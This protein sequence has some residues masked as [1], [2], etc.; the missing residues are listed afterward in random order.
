MSQLGTKISAAMLLVNKNWTE[1]SLNQLNDAFDKIHQTLDDVK[2][3][4][5]NVSAAINI[6]NSIIEKH[7][8][9]LYRCFSRKP[10]DIESVA[11]CLQL[12]TSM[13]DVNT[14]TA[15]EVSS[16][17]NF[18]YKPFTNLAR[19]HYE[20]KDSPR[21]HYIK[22][23][24][25]I[26]RCG[27]LEVITQSLKLKDFFQV[28]IKNLTDDPPEL[29]LNVLTTFL[30]RV[31][32]NAE[33]PK[34]IKVLFFNSYNLSQFA[35]LYSNT[36]SIPKSNPTLQSNSNFNKLIRKY[37]SDDS[38]R[39]E[40]TIS[41]RVLIHTFL[42]YIC[43]SVKHG[44]CFASKSITENKKRSMTTT[45]NPILLKF[46]QNINK[47][48]DDT[49]VQNLICRIAAN[50][51][52]VAFSYV[53]N[54]PIAIEPTASNWVPNM[55]LL[56]RLLTL[57]P[58]PPAE[59]LPTNC[60]T[61]NIAD[62]ILPYIIP[63]IVSRST[64]SRILQNPSHLT[65]LTGLNILLILLQRTIDFVNMQRQ[66]I[67]NSNDGILN[68]T[69]A[70]LFA[71][72]PDIKT[73]IKMKSLLSDSG[74]V[75]DVV[76]LR[77]V[78]VMRKYQELSPT[79][80]QME[81]GRFDVSNM[82]LQTRESTN[83]SLEL[84]LIQLLSNVPIDSFKWLQTKSSSSSP[85]RILLSIYQNTARN[86]TR[87]LTLSLIRKILANTGLFEK[88]EPE[89]DLWIECLRDH[90][91]HDIAFINDWLDETIRQLL[92]NPY[93]AIGV[94]TSEN[95]KAATSLN[96]GE[97]PSLPCSP[98]ASA[99]LLC[100]S[101]YM[102]SD[103]TEN[104]PI[105]RNLA[106]Y[107]GR[108]FKGISRY[109]CDVLGIVHKLV[110][111]VIDKEILSSSKSLI[112]NMWKLQHT[113][114]VLYHGN[115]DKFLSGFW[116]SDKIEQA[117]NP[118]IKDSLKLAMNRIKIKE[119]ESRSIKK[120]LYELLAPLNSNSIYSSLGD[121][122]NFCKDFL[123]NDYEVVINIVRHRSLII[124]GKP[125]GEECLKALLN[126]YTISDLLEELFSLLIDSV[127][128][129]NSEN[130][131]YIIPL[132]KRKAGN[133]DLE[134]TSVSPRKLK[135]LITSDSEP[136]YQ[137][138]DIKLEPYI[139]TIV[140][141]SIKTS[142]ISSDNVDV[143]L[144]EF[145]YYVAMVMSSF[146][147]EKAVSDEVELIV[148]P[149]F[150]EF[151][152]KICNWIDKVIA[153][154][155]NAESIILNI[156]SVILHNCLIDL[157]FELNYSRK[158]LLK[159]WLLGYARVV[160]T[161][162]TKLNHGN[163]KEELKDRFIMKYISKLGCNYDLLVHEQS[164]LDDYK[165]PDNIDVDIWLRLVREFCSSFDAKS[166]L[167]I[168]N[169]VLQSKLPQDDFRCT[170]SSVLPHILRNDT[171][172]S[173]M[174]E[175]LWFNLVAST[176]NEDFGSLETAIIDVMLQH[177]NIRPLPLSTV[178]Y[179][180]KNS[181]SC[182]KMFAEMFWP[183]AFNLLHSIP[184]TCDSPNEKLIYKIVC[185]LCKLDLIPEN[186]RDVLHEILTNLLH[187][188]DFIWNKYQLLILATVT[189]KLDRETELYFIT[190][191]FK[192]LQKLL[193]QKVDENQITLMSQYSSIVQAKLT[194]SLC[195]SSTFE[196][197]FW[198]NFVDAICMKDTFFKPTIDTLVTSID[199]I[200][201]IKPQ[202]ISEQ[203]TVL[204]RHFMVLISTH[205]SLLPLF[206]TE[207]NQQTL[208][209]LQKYESNDFPIA[210]VC[211]PIIWGPA[212]KEY[213]KNRS[214]SASFQ[215]LWEQ[216]SMQEILSIL[217]R[218]QM[219]KSIINFPL[220]RNLKAKIAHWTSYS[221]DPTLYDPCFLLPLFC[222]LLQPGCV[223][224]CHQF[225]ERDCLCYSAAALT[226][227]ED[228][229]RA[230]GYYILST[231]ESVAADSRFREKTQIFMV[232]DTLKNSITSPNYKLAGITVN[233]IACY[234]D[235]VL[236]PE[237]KM[238]LVLNEY[239]LKKPTLN[240]RSLHLFQG[241][242][243]SP[244]EKERSWALNLLKNSFRRIEDYSLY[245]KEE[246]TLSLLCYYNSFSC[247]T[248][249]QDA[250]F[251]IFYN[252]CKIPSIAV[253][254]LKH[255]GFINWIHILLHDKRRD[256]TIRTNHALNI[257]LQLWTAA[258]NLSD[259]RVVN[260][261]A[262]QVFPLCL[263]VMK[264][265][266][267]KCPSESQIN[268]LIGLLDS[269]T[270]YFASNTEPLCYASEILNHSPSYFLLLLGSLIVQVK[271]NFYS[272]NS[273]LGSTSGL[274][275]QIS[276]FLQLGVM[277]DK[278]T[279][280][281]LSLQR[282][283]QKRNSQTMKE[284]IDAEWHLK[285]VNIIIRCK[286]T[287]NTLR[288]LSESLPCTNHTSGNSN[289]DGTVQNNTEPFIEVLHELFNW[290]YALMKI[291]K[292]NE[293]GSYKTDGTKME[294]CDN[295]Q[296]WSYLSQND[297][298]I[299]LH[300][301]LL[302]VPALRLSILRSENS[303]KRLLLMYK[304]YESFSNMI[305]KWSRLNQIFII[306]WT[307][308]QKH[309]VY[310]STDYRNYMDKI[311]KLLTADSSIYHQFS[312][313]IL[314]Q[315]DAGL[316]EAESPLM[317]HEYVIVSTGLITQ[318]LWNEKLQPVNFLLYIARCACFDGSSSMEIGQN[319][320]QQ[321]M[322]ILG[323]EK[324]VKQICKFKDYF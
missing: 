318:E 125:I 207:K 33:L 324:K 170:I 233:L 288:P 309:S 66:I 321:L 293:A 252:A 153:V 37:Q 105:L 143:L 46:L 195:Q 243:T 2:E 278:N 96:K 264:Y 174:P 15:R 119:N 205:N 198:K 35:S 189:A 103:K 304:S 241:L 32:N 234:V 294:D 80:F 193:D 85:F 256:S 255:Y 128:V 206:A 60:N 110:L 319:Y 165:N 290:I 13:V 208:Y 126:Q 158:A 232:L 108:I 23:A 292:S 209:L 63:A 223:V 135:K 64:L 177:V 237:D 268:C 166:N 275:F 157:C 167:K 221:D 34:K 203:L 61:Q 19:R 49:L 155:N 228:D 242:F 102:E 163:S 244:N 299:W 159:T 181:V 44:V 101:R 186:I 274:K 311:C 150:E 190:A 289:S 76:K 130:S 272:N 25:A 11:F 71:H 10:I 6:V 20:K 218:K 281:E 222:G 31:I 156:A 127:I 298:M 115:L 107:L 279:S 98:L 141:N 240:L 14:I 249:S 204:Y 12:L 70:S 220:S 139:S 226:S 300:H 72:L 16:N 56:C 162:Y 112:F 144:R 257:L 152:N 263:I 231:F 122:V 183:N 8:R 316:I 92:Q 40:D 114:I 38:N 185:H 149:A 168:L 238:Y 265:F 7:M 41:I 314:P 200:S 191:C 74:E 224:D 55:T 134:G 160:F 259:V 236:H 269:L 313:K 88:N 81:S 18:S 192:G 213:F 225:L 113:S 1:L 77:F 322:D 129:A 17:F 3:E 84:E 194:E 65:Q 29:I 310:D 73:I 216:P 118:T 284:H 123:K 297:L 175:N 250:I 286:F 154:D 100:Y 106:Q 142:M 211:S 306:L 291:H 99:S 276:K 251:Q 196:I 111:K 302:H 83:E 97:G 320:I 305:M 26:L 93:D 285:I 51:H 307:E 197:D 94:L 301:L 246:I 176:I 117:V 188:E 124:I 39:N 43:C 42:C 184:V 215:T 91:V 229:I 172:I 36:Q 45:N 308:L 132:S 171:L 239:L 161:T 140:L 253:S 87:K 282:L 133:N 254:L 303:I 267:K 151:F 312:T 21:Y 323:G 47:M 214:K 53:Q 116:P 22:F 82:L 137:H 69:Q 4:K 28:I 95:A 199:I 75:L 67:G 260:D 52:D 48:N 280:T 57:L 50:C 121:I 138:T 210:N 182:L 9:C 227:D 78:Q 262:N 248:E 109:R 219:R 217:D 180:L 261:I 315:F 86:Q 30:D 235:V 212:A 58:K 173:Q 287:N 283:S 295:S 62:T 270:N 59:L 54:L 131:S 146:H 104:Y 266:S 230:M 277:N 24:L 169:I 187:R 136:S 273:N 27:D 317:N 147:I 245:I 258:K 68:V 5:S 89:I 271:D 247:D 202:D 178:N 120:E 145:L 296:N 79:I 90:S 148:I 179:C 201:K 164:Q